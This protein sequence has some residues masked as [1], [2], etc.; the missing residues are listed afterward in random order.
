MTLYFIVLQTIMSSP[1]KIPP[2]IYHHI[3][4]YLLDKKDL[5]WDSGKKW[6]LH[7]G[8]LKNT[9]CINGKC[10]SCCNINCIDR[11][12]VYI[13][14]QHTQPFTE[15]ELLFVLGHFPE[16]TKTRPKSRTKTKTKRQVQNLD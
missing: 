8:E 7:C 2:E 9:Y 16:I 14:Y 1:I 5:I 11:G 6:C 13:T 15:E 10:T 4:L 3:M 12:N